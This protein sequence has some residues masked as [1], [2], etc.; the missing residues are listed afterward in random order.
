[1]RA[2]RVNLNEGIDCPKQ[3]LLDSVGFFPGIVLG[4][5]SEYGTP[6]TDYLVETLDHPLAIL[7]EDE[8]YVAV[9]KPAGLM[10]HRGPR[11][12]ASEPVLLQSLRDQLNRFVY[13][14]HRLDRPTAGLILFGLTRDAA[15]RMGVLFEQRRVRKHYQALVRGHMLADVT[16]D[17]ALIDLPDRWLVGRRDAE[18]AQ[19]L[20]PSG[21][22]PSEGIGAEERSP[23][24]SSGQAAVTHFHPL[25]RYEVDWPSGDFPTSRFTLLEIEPHT[26]RWHQ[27]RRHLNHLA[28]PVIGD[29]RHGDHR[30]NQRFFERTGIYRM[31]LTAMRLE[32]RHPFTEQF[33]TLLVQP[34]EA[35]E[36]ALKA[37]AVR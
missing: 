32:F 25:Q 36:T 35:F 21:S 5:T 10:V 12:L 26:G 3:R 27:I 23:E 14:I 30:W 28:H 7:Y 31:L 29:H 22:D 4:M 8:H 24:E 34:G 1:M 18:R 13:P 20:D 15:S 33:V 16:V 17:R 9:F 11:T 2:R 19:I 37:L 6:T